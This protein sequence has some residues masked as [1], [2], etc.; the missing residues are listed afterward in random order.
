M[1][2]RARRWRRVV[3][4]GCAGRWWRGA[5]V[6]KSGLH[7]RRTPLRA[8]AWRRHADAVQLLRDRAQAEPAPAETCDPLRQFGVTRAEPRPPAGPLRRAV[9]ALDLFEQRHHPLPFGRARVEP[10][11]SRRQVRPGLPQPREQRAEL[12]Q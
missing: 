9:P 11:V 8:T 2:S 10:Y 5:P 12:S 3:T 7:A 4:A 1:R 6:T